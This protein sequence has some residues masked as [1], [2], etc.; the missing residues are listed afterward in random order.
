MGDID[1]TVGAWGFARGGM[2]AVSKALGASLEASGGEIRVDAPVEQILVEGGR[3]RGVLLASGERLHAKLVVS[4]MD[5]RRTFLES[6]AEADL[7]TDFLR[8][9]R[10]FKIR[11]SS[12]QLSLA[13]NRRRHSP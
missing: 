11:G 10:T 6:M 13:L 12:G 3:A 9:V 2:G 4:N 1:E 8:Q 7:P 5:V